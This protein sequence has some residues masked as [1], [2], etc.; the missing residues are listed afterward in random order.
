MVIVSVGGSSIGSN[1]SNFMS[2]A[3][4]NRTRTRITPQQGESLFALANVAPS[5]MMVNALRSMKPEMFILLLLFRILVLRRL[6]S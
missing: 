6:P 1:L 5:A 4:G 3:D 2:D